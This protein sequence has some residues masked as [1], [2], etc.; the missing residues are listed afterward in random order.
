MNKLNYS[1]ERR[2][3]VGVDQTCVTHACYMTFA[4][5]VHFRS[6]FVQVEFLGENGSDTG[7]FI[8]GGS[9]H[10]LSSE[11]VYNYIHGMG[12]SDVIPTLEDIPDNGVK[13]SVAC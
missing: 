12:I 1:P 2:I 3:R 6:C 4:L 10:H 7:A 9:G 13:E 11:S 8:Q 5:G